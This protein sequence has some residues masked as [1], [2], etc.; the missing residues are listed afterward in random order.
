MSILNDLGICISNSK[1]C[2]KCD[3]DKSL[4]EFRKDKKSKGGY[5]PDCKECAKEYSKKYR[6]E[7]K[8]NKESKKEYSKKYREE[9]KEHLK[10]QK[11]KWD[12][13]NKE[14]LKEKAKKY[15]EENRE[16]LNEK[17][18]KYREENKEKVKESQKK[19][20]PKRNESDK[21]RKQSD[22]LF[23][24]T[25]NLR[26]RMYSAIKEGMGFTKYGRS[27]ELLGCTFEEVREHIEIQF[28]DGMTW[29]NQ[30]DWHIDHMRPC[31]SFDLTKEDQQ[32]E[33][34]HYTNL[35]PLWAF[36]NLSKGANWEESVSIE[37]FE[38][39]FE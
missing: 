14:Q 2:S 33:C 29:K 16:K 13:E 25:K 23:K 1:T 38:D 28:K 34:F 20:Q 39:L 21:K 17:A 22:P 6:E 30:G 24:L 26:N 9:N 4:E 19:Y 10:E 3:I 5:R 8:E 32:R 11:K 35:Q 36:D 7:N 27:E 31:E 37:D 15:R 18:K 12:E